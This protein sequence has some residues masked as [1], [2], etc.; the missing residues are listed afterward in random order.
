MRV[1]KPWP[2]SILLCNPGGWSGPASVPGNATG[3]FLVS[4]I[5][6][7]QVPMKRVHGRDVTRTFSAIHD[8]QRMAP[9]VDDMNAFGSRTA[10]AWQ[11]RGE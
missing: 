2:A 4:R 6:T 9:I 10:I 11:R 7:P 8:P 5:F 1:L 3:P